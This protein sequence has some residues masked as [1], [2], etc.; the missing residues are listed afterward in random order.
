MFLTLTE[1]S[2]Y[3]LVLNRFTSIK[4]IELFI[5]FE[6]NLIIFNK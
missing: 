3:S 6:I 5:K 2:V 1:I 4:G